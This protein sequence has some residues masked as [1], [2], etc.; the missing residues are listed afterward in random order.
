MWQ[1]D[2]AIRSGARS[3]SRF[4]MY[5]IHGT[6][7]PASIGRAASSG[8]IRM[9]NDHVIELFEQVPVGTRVEVL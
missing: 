5:R 8:C 1:A 6:T 9:L 4:L 7:D 3:V 2:R